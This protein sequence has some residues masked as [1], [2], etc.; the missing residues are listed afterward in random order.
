[1]TYMKIIEIFL[2]CG[3][4]RGMCKKTAFYIGVNGTYKVKFFTFCG[5]VNS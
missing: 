2:H 4:E 1:M 3:V 5:Y